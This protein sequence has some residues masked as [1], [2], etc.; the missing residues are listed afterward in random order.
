MSALSLHLALTILCL[1]SV[2]QY[3]EFIDAIN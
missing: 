3:V 1:Q 2:W